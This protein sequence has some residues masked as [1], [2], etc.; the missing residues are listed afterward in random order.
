MELAQL[1]FLVMDEVDKYFEMGF[2]RQVK[3]LLE[4]FKG[5]DNI[6]Y[7]MFSATVQREVEVLLKDLT[8]DYIR[9][10]IGGR[11]NVLNTIEQKLS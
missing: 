1:E 11:N 7:L 9:V 4:I 8:S 3:Q 5:H 2:V 10:L 6:C